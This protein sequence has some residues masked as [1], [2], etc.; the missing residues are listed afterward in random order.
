MKLLMEN[1]NNYLTEQQFR[2]E[3][4]HYITENNIALTEEQL[5]EIN[6]K[7]IARKFAT[8]AALLAAMA[9]SNPALG[10]DDFASM[11]DD[12]MSQQ[13][14]QRAAQADTEGSQNLAIQMAQWA[15]QN[16]PNAPQANTPIAIGG[17][18]GSSVVQAAAGDPDAFE[19]AFNQ[20]YSEGMAAKG[21]KVV[22]IVL[23][24][25]GM[26]SKKADNISFSVEH[27]NGQYSVSL[28]G[29]GID[30]D[31]AWQRWNP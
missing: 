29:P 5:N 28:Q 30:D 20:A 10:N 2:D 13:Q 6:W 31:L 17:Y 24:S 7:Q 16:T 15:L 1:W 12:A 4:I 27:D 25:A 23:G 11:F 9:A 3:F 18:M 14:T 19:S 22:D 21:Y 26:M 8:P